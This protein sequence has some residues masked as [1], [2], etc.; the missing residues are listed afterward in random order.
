MD[1][2]FQTTQ[3]PKDLKVSI[4]DRLANQ[5]LKTAG[6][7]IKFLFTFLLIGLIFILIGDGFNH[8]TFKAIGIATIIVGWLVIAAGFLG[9]VFHYLDSTGN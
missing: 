6:D 3:K 2:R 8:L 1:P 9:I 5:S 4:W 7:R